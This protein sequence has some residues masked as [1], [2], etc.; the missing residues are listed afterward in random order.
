MAGAM[1]SGGR[2]RRGAMEGGAVKIAAAVLKALVL[3]AWTAVAVIVAQLV[4]GYLLIW[5]LGRE[6][7]VQ[8]VWTSV[9]SAVAYI[10]AFVLL[11]LLTPKLLDLWGWIKAKLKNRAEEGAEGGVKNRVG[12]KIEG[13]T[14][15]EVGGKAEDN[16]GSEVGDKAENTARRKR[17]I[18]RNDKI[19]H[20]VATRTELGLKG[21]P[22]WTDVG[23]AP[24]G[25]IVSTLAAVGLSALFTLFPWYSSEEA[26]DLSYS[27]SIEGG[28]R[29]LAFLVLA[30]VVPFAEELIFRGWLYGKVRELLSDKMRKWVAIA[31]SIVIVSLLFALLHGQWNVGLTVFAMSVV[32]CILREMTGSIY[33]GIFMHMIRNAL[34]FYVLYILKM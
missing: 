14:G 11:W 27:T 26:Q 21:L 31:V 34:A 22:T 24:V 12:G 32:A 19:A 20:K 9:Y 5:I 18:A 15:S 2:G 29:V 7:L 17:V 33:A 6:L 23:L 1:R 28:E 3:A 13:N 25:Y 4:V 30:V 16:A 8:P 10:L